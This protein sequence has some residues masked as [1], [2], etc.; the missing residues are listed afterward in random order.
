MPE[1]MMPPEDEVLAFMRGELAPDAAQRLLT[2]ARGDAKLMRQLEY[3]RA[4]AGDAFADAARADDAAAF[5]RLQARI[6]VARPKPAAGSAGWLRTLGEWLRTYAL[7]VQG[8]LA[9]VAVALAVA[10][11]GT[12]TRTAPNP[13]TSQ[14]MLRGPTESCLVVGVLFK[15]GVREDQIGMWLTEYNASIVSGPD[16]AGVY[17]IRLPDA[18]TFQQFIHDPQAT[19]LA[20]KLQ[21]IPGCAK[22]ASQN[23]G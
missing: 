10:L 5:A 9:T 11:A 12:L 13:S 15:A 19:A 17:K 2:R 1:P 14:S 18:G 3:L 16:A 23:S 6:A 22:P 21:L 8:A 20:G 4:A 7:P